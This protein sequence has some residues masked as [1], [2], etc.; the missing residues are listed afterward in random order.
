MKVRN[1]SAAVRYFK[2]KHYPRPGRFPTQAIKLPTRS[3]KVTVRT[4]PPPS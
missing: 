4:K 1:A 2:L 3:Q